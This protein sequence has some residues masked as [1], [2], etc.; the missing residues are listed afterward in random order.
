MPYSLEGK[1]FNSLTSNQPTLP[2]LTQIMQPINWYINRL[3]TMSPSEIA[4]RI[5]SLFR[6]YTDRVRIPL[7]LYPGIEQIKDTDTEAIKPGFQMPTIHLGAWADNSAT[8]Q[9]KVWLAALL[10]A[11]DEIIAHRFSYF[12]LNNFNH[13]TPIDWHRDHAS[14]KPAPLRL[15]NTIDYRDFHETGDCKF[16]WEPNRHHHL[17]ILARAYRASNQKKYCEAIKEQ[18]LS[19][20]DKNPFGF[21]MN[22]RSPLELSIRLINWVWA[23]DLIRESGVLTGTFHKHILHAVYLHL[24]EV[25][26]KYSKG[27]SANNHLIG[28]AA[29]V[30]IAC[31]Y[32]PS[33]PNAGQWRQQSYDILC[34]ESLVQTYAD[35]GNKELA[36]GYHYFVLQFLLFSGLAGRWSGMDFPTSYWDTIEKMMDFLGNLAKGGKPPLYGDCD[37]GYVLNLGNS[38][39]DSS[40]L[41]AVGATL[42]SRADFK[43]LSGD[44]QEPL[45][46]LFGKDGTT[47]FELLP[48][49]SQKRLKSLALSN[50]GLYLLQNGHHGQEDCISL[51]ADCGDLGYTSI[52]AH[53]HADALSFTLRAAGRDVLVD[54]GTYDYFSFPNLRNYFRSTSAHNTVE[55]DG[56]NQSV[57][58]GPFLWG[59]KAASRCLS[60][61]PSPEGGRFI[62]EHDGYQRLADPVTHRR[63]II[64]ND[65]PTQ[66]VTVNDEILG[67]ASHTIKIFFHF[68]PDCVVEEIDRNQYCISLG[69]KKISLK[70]DSKLSIE[71]LNGKEEPIA[72]WFSPGYH[73]RAACTTLVG[74]MVSTGACSFQSVLT[75]G[76]A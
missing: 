40:A 33:L 28:E 54:P 41:L 50:S 29:G 15:S 17:V 37:D 26:R 76:G 14:N 38:P 13:G 10:S 49:S 48:S 42:F 68:A 2:L 64:L 36:L 51:L 5:S 21:G 1:L 47:G 27:T 53:G 39:H 74:K 58:L 66:T 8:T 4:W 44:A 46:W 67:S 19:W 30:F 63:T 73:S 52:A 57:I 43:A 69:D 71:L 61:D 59:K 11:A 22:W 7:R 34:Q 45:H 3:K 65:A 55:I 6:D 16:V 60:W 24:W 56:Q 23:F 31:C 70:L 32:F 72:G 20:L 12:N 75:V 18:L 62:G 35:G 9:E 25:T